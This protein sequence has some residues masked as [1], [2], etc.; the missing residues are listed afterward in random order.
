MDVLL[1][2]ITINSIGRSGPGVSPYFIGLGFND[3]ISYVKIRLYDPIN[4]NPPENATNDF[5]IDDLIFSTS[6]PVPE[7]AT[8][9]L[10]GFGLLT[11]GHEATP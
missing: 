3:Q 2:E 11:L 10:L 1:D 8:L 9:C 4:G 7:P 6:S 5:E